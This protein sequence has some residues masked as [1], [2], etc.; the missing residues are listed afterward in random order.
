MEIRERR[1][2]LAIKQDYMGVAGKL[3]MI[4][5][6]LGHPIIQ[7]DTGMMDASYLDDPYDMDE[8]ETMPTTHNQEIQE[9]GHA[10]D[11]L[12]SGMHLEIRYLYHKQELTVEYKGH[13]VYKEVAGD[14][15]AFA[16][17]PEWENLITL[18]YV[19]A[20]A[21]RKKLEASMEPLVE[22]IVQVKKQGWLQKMRY[23]WGI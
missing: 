8:E 14:L 7:E 17:F 5:K 13:T 11:G 22:E 19:R 12:S 3:G 18:L 1:T 10:F 21:R 20:K 23:R 4:A 9:V 16:P 2:N 15:F 6:F